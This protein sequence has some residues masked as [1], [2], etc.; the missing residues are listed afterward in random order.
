[1]KTARELL[2]HYE[3]YPQAVANKSTKSWQDSEFRS[4][5]EAVYCAFDWES[6]P[7]GFTFW[8]RIINELENEE[9]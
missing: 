4:P 6:S 2:S 5:S 9:Q 3:W 7:E 8:M 1:M